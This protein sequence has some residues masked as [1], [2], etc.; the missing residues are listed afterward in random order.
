MADDRDRLEEL[1]Q[2]IEQHN[3]RY[4][5]LDDPLVS[6]AEWDAL[7]RELLELE[8]R[9]PGWVTPESPSQRVHGAPAAGFN[10]VEHA[11]AMLSLDNATSADEIR[12]FDTRV[13]KFLGEKSPIAYC[14]EP[15]YDG[16]AV[17]LT[18]E[19]GVFRI[20]STR[21]DGRTG[22]DV[23][24]NLR[25]IRSVPLRLRGSPPQV[26]DVR[27]EAFMPLAAFRRLNEE[28][29][30]EGLQPF[31]NPRNSTA[32]TLRQ[33]DPKVA[34]ARPLEIVIYGIG[35]GHDELGFGSQGES[36]AGL[37]EFGLKT[38]ELFCASY[39]IDE[40]IAFHAKLENE[41]DSLRYE[42]DGSVLKVDDFAL[43]KRLGELNRSPRWAIAFKFP[44]RQSTTRVIGIE[45]S[46][47]R[48][49]ALTPVAV[50]EPVAI[51][52]VTVE[53]ASLHNQDEIERLDV[54][55][56]DTVFV[57]RAGDVIPK[58]V[59][60]VL[61]LRP[62]RTR[63][64]K[65]PENCPVCDTPAVRPEGEVVKRCPNPNCPAKQ[66]ERLRH[67]ASRGA[68]D[69]EGLG[70]KLVDQLIDAELLTRP[71]DLFGLKIDRIA[72]LDRMGQKSAQNLVSAIENS[73]DVSLGRFLYAL[74]IR[75]VGER[76]GEVLAASFP[77]PITLLDAS[78]QELE[79]VD[80]IG[81]TIAESLRLSLDEPENRA[82]FLQL[83]DTLRIQSG[84]ELEVGNESE[85]LAGKTVVI[86]GTLSIPRSQWKKR[87][88]AAGAKVTGS[89][90]KKT[91]YLLAGENPGSKLEKARECEVEVV[92]EDRMEELLG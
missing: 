31:A 28:R 40:L 2:L 91:D 49:G 32:G 67:F 75:H 39:E 84:P 44:A 61:D 52:G 41:R 36:I 89:V 29:L 76:I 43:Q 27:G 57:E 46:V 22:E 37:R 7:M 24:H 26:L 79:E 74:G 42:I 25:T 1:R 83:V 18:Y 10:A 90:S 20:G 81:P 86:T 50:L 80:E 82:E 66:R 65:P 47:G 6:D 71:S 73:R 17:E 48:T 19:R 53:H 51:G 85:A 5:I 3:Y 34:A 88:L 54:R 68:L 45:T 8:A 70:E 21:G 87:I 62:G 11:V 23:S 58:V 69:V 77:D 35:R 92:G 55:V 64:H 13:R 72:A 33:L 30:D 9:H 56:G 78:K 14:I 4:H 15:K 38:S 12:A 16:I 60:V 59:R 63:R